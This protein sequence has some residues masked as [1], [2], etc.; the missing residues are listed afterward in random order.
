MN[1]IR[2]TAKTISTKQFNMSVDVLSDLF[3]ELFES[4][5]CHRERMNTVL[6]PIG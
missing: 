6:D 5:I 3:I 2:A 4:R 1:S